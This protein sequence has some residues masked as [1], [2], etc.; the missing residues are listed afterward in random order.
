MPDLVGSAHTERLRLERWDH[1]AHGAGL[2]AMNAQPEVVEYLGGGAGMTR[3]ESDE[4]SA[5]IAA[6][7]TTYGFGLWAAVERASGEMVGFVG[8]SHPAWWPAMIDRVEVG[9]RLR[10]EA[11]GAGYA[12]EGARAALRAGFE[13][14]ELAE[15]VSF[16][17]PANERS[18]AVT[19]RLGMKVEG[20]L[21]HPSRPEPVTILSIAVAAGR[22]VS[23]TR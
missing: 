13:T 7:W 19:R 20:E 18:L 1:E 8:L 17:H 22:A 3:A 15:I 23:T 6:H 14:L 21:P 5:R 10:R 11:W 16:V 4:A 2:A 9:W 12:T